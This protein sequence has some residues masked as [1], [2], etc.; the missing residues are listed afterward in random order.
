MVFI[1]FFK[2]EAD[3][4]V[5]VVFLEAVALLKIEVVAFVRTHRACLNIVTYLVLLLL[6]LLSGNLKNSEEKK[7]ARAP[8]T[9]IRRENKRPINHKKYHGGDEA[10][11]SRRFEEVQEQEQQR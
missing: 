3:E 6:L 11:G 4:G 1:F 10:N 7:S 9:L 5:F 8:R 2:K